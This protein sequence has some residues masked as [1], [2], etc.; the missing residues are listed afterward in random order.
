MPSDGSTAMSARD[1]HVLMAL[2]E[3]D[4]HGYG[5]MK[6]VERDSGGRVTVEVGSLYR[7][8]DRLM[9]EG[10]VEEVAAPDHAPSET[11]GR[12][13]RYFRLAAAGR[14]ALRRE[15]M[16]LRDALDLARA[17]SLLPEPHR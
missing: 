3:E 2:L 11:R 16:R 7:V 14:A 15:T 1:W 10:M 12:P 5:I 9:E 17:R 13:R 4:L 8:L 6:A